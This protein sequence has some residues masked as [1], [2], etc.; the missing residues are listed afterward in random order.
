MGHT[1]V[2]SIGFRH[3]LVARRDFATGLVRLAADRGFSVL[4]VVPPS[5]G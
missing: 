4:P 3:V 2:G 1:P 5:R